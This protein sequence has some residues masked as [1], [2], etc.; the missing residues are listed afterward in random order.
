MEYNT[1]SNN[2]R[3]I[4]QSLY[5]IVQKKVL[6]TIHLKYKHAIYCPICCKYYLQM[7]YTVYTSKAIIV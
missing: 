2:C 4:V 6:Y 7:Q 3:Y 1:L 5:N